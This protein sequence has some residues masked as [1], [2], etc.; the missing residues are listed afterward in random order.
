MKAVRVLVRKGH[1]RGITKV[2]LANAAG[3]S[4]PTLDEMLR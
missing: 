2:R 4:R 1:R 3:V